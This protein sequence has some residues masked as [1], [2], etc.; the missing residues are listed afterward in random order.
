MQVWKRSYSA[1]LPQFLNLTTS[2]TQQFSEISS[3]A[4]TWQHQ[5]RSKSARL[6]QFSKLTTSKTKQFCET[7]FKNGKLSAELTASYQCVLR[8]F[9]SICVK[10]CTCHSDSRSYQVLHRSRKIILANLRS[11]APKFNPLRKSAPWPPSISGE[12]VSCTAPATRNASAQILFKCPTPAI[13]FGTATKPSRFAHFW[14]CT[15]SLA[16]ATPN[17]IWTSKSGPSVCLSVKPCAARRVGS[18]NS[19]HVHT[20]CRL[21][22]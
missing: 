22:T 11:G 9:H 3:N 4:L 1:R 8:F 6:P 12:H 17:N 19:I 10:R 16:P 13:V 20:T 15:E 5:K 21:K 14:P 18:S 2:K 7:S